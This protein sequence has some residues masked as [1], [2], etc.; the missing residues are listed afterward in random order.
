MVGGDAKKLLY[1]PSTLQAA[2][3]DMVKFTFM[4]NNHTVTQST[5]PK[6]CVKMAGGVDSGFMPNVNNTVSPPPNYMFQV[7]DTKP[8]CKSRPLSSVHRFVQM[9]IFQRVLLPAKNTL[10]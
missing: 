4:A 1:T 5:F 2:A 10:R 6:P 8:V 7:L 3:G 9:L